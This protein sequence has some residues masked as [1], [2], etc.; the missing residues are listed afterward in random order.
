MIN[1]GHIA[2]AYGRTE[3]DAVSSASNKSDA[4]QRGLP[5]L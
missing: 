4:A 5:K 2:A 3:S 1:H